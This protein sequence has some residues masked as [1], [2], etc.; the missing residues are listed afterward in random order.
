MAT[1]KT[2]K[3][4]DTKGFIILSIIIVFGLLVLLQLSKQQQAAIP[5]SDSAKAPL[6]GP[7]VVRSGASL[8]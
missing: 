8:K 7:S 4:E 2:A 1:H 5:G 3:Q 6:V